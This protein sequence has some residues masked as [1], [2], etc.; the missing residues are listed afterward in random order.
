MKT[1]NHKQQQATTS[2]NIKYYN[3]IIK[4]TKTLMFLNNI[5][6][7]L[8]QRPG[9]EDE[10]H[11]TRDIQKQETKQNQPQEQEPLKPYDFDDLGDEFC[12]SLSI[13]VNPSYAT[14]LSPVFCQNTDIYEYI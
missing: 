1:S 12:C 3:Q 2:N 8:N 14:K 13:S 9:N 5:C 7:Y 6:P 10:N 4:K 11:T